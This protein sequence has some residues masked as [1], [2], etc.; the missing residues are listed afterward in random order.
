MTQHATDP[1]RMMAEIDAA[2]PAWPLE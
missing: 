1:R 2:I